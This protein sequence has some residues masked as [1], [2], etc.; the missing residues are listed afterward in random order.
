MLEEFE[1]LRPAF[2]NPIFL[3]LHRLAVLERE[4]IGQILLRGQLGGFRKFGRGHAWQYRT[5][6]KCGKQ[7]R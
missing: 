2:L 4:W 3:G 1:Q 7:K 6:D 5:P